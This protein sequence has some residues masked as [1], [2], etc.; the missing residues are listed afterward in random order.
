MVKLDHMKR[1]A[2]ALL[3]VALCAGGLGLAYAPAASATNYFI[4]YGSFPTWY[5]CTGG[6]NTAA[7][8]SWP[9]QLVNEN[10]CS[11]RVWLKQYFPPENGWN[12]CVPPRVISWSIPSWAWYPQDIQITSNTAPCP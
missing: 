8:Q 1:R 2:S 4:P 9:V 7:A 12:Y 5:P 10:Q 3:V 6:K 11:V